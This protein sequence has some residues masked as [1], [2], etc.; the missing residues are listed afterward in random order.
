MVKM[1]LEI[2][3]MSCGMCESH[4]NDTIRRAFSVRKVS[5]SHSKG[6]TELIAENPIDEEALR[7]AIDET[8]YV[9]VSVKTEPY[10]KKGLF[11]RFKSKA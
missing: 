10:E 2:E 7:K 11:G 8:G 4:V 9:L 3:G 5:S 6:Q 1:T